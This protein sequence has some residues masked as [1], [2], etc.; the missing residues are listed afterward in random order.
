MKSVTLWDLLVKIP[1]RRTITG[2][3]Y[4]L[5]SVLA[6]ALTA[7]LCGRASLAAIARFS[8]RLPKKALR[9]LGVY[10]EEAPC[11]A[12][13][14]NVFHQIDLAVLEQTLA[15]WVRGLAGDAALEHVAIDGKRL[16]GSKSGEA[17]GMHLLTAYCTALSGVIGQAAMGGDE[18]EITAALRLL[19]NMPLRGIIITGDAM[20][21]QKEICQTIINNGGDYFFHGKGKPGKFAKRDSYGVC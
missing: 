9:E 7:I 21:T 3:R 6:L 14:H 1:D 13:Y 11:P 15:L 5:A 10:R 4:R 16:R 12:T 19:K 2:R 20:F 17:P 8:R 18:N